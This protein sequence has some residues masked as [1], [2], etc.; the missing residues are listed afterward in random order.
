MDIECVITVRFDGMDAEDHEL[1]LF[2]LGE[3]MQGFARI[4]GTIGNFVTTHEYSRYFRSHQLR[5]LAKEPRGNC[6]SFDVVFEFVRQHQMLAGTVP[7]ALTGLIGWLIHR[8]TKKEIYNVDLNTQLLETLRDMAAQNAAQT[9]RLLT[10]M[11]RMAEDLRPSLKQ[12]F[13]PVGVSCRTLTVITP[14]RTDT[15]DETDK[16]TLMLPLNDE[17]TDLQEWVVLITELDL[18]RGTCKARLVSDP[19][20]RR[21]NAVITDPVLKRPNNPYSLAMAGGEPIP[22]RAKAHIQEGT[23]KRLYISDVGI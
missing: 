9:N 12:T 16:A 10:I 17:I 6:Y 15:Y 22:I 20:E 5:V 4:A 3:S 18:E 23:I 8:A 1:E 2:S 13:A 7:A 11:E 19:E 21:V 14:Q